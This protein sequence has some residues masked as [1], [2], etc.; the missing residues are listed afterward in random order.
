MRFHHLGVP[1]DKPREGEYHL[2][3][4]GVYVLDYRSNPYGIEW[5]RYEPHCTLPEIIKTVPHLAFV[6]PD[7]DAAIE[8]KEIISQPSTPTEGVRVAMIEEHGAPIEFMEIADEVA[9]LY[10]CPQV[11]ED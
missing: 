5:M 9:H 11:V 2:P 8:G 4:A 1:T 6:V 10:P 7:L 3:E